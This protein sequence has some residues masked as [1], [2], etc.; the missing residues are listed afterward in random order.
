MKLSRTEKTT[1]INKGAIVRHNTNKLESIEL[2]MVLT[3]SAPQTAYMKA[4]KL[5]MI[6]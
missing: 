2:I 4:K 5:M 1:A 3:V 6:V